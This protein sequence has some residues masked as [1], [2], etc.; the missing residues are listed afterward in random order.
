MA[1]VT[2]DV[3]VYGDHPS[4]VT[5]A[6]AA[7]QAGL[8][9]V[10]FTGE[11]RIGSPYTAG[12]NRLD[13]GTRGSRAMGSWILRQF[14]ELIARYHVGDR[15]QIRAMSSLQYEMCLRDLLK[16]Y[17]VIVLTGPDW[18][19][20]ESAGVTKSLG[21]ITAVNCDGGNSIIATNYIDCS[22]DGDLAR[23]A[24]C[25]MRVGRESTTEFSETLAGFRPSGTIAV[26]DV[27]SSTTG[28]GYVWGVE[29]DPGYQAGTLL[30]GDADPNSAQSFG[31][32]WTVTDDPYNQRRWPKP[33]NY[34]E[35]L[36]EFEKRTLASALAAGT[37]QPL[38]ALLGQLMHGKVDPNDDTGW[39]QV[40]WCTATRAQRAVIYDTM[41][42]TK[43]GLMWYLANSSDVHDD[44][45]RQ[46]DTWRPC[47]DEF[48]DGST[49][50][51]TAAGMPYTF[52]RRGTLRLSGGTCGYIMR[53]SDLQE[54]ATN[55]TDS[56]STGHYNIDCHT[57]RKFAVDGG[58]GYMV[59][60]LQTID[61]I[62]DLKKITPYM[63]PAACH[64][65]T[66]FPNLLVVNCCAKTFVADCSMRIDMWKMTQ[67]SACG[68]WAARSVI[69]ATPIQS[70]SITAAVTGLQARIQALGGVT[71][72]G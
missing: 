38:G 37:Y 46:L 25:T 12:L 5:A 14:L 42:R 50:S 52:Y 30:P 18:Y 15:E 36:F 24:G 66:D 65:Q 16:W 32:R 47:Y 41:Y 40:A 48:A 2:C 10:L 33:D 61:G 71:T 58:A 55:K 7:A 63:I 9:V 49:H 39:N 70:Y 69:E 1:N 68:L 44:V 27:T 57:V 6:C 60:S 13:V 19:I 43:A 51:H 56:I 64:Y 54:N 29:A 53:Q 31:F 22:E 45:R 67:G 23:F 11:Y 28:T 34:D 26:A 59:D 17:G 20:K 4:A 3:A 72:P 62:E 8:R 35:E 21:S